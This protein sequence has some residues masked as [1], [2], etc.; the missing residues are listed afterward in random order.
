MR[1]FTVLATVWALTFSYGA[2]NRKSVKG[3][4]HADNTQREQ[5]PS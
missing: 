2:S 5:E 3:N 4:K 1:K